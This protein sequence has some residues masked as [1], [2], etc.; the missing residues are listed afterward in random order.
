MIMIWFEV[1]R[2]IRSYKKLLRNILFNFAKV[3]TVEMYYCCKEGLAIFVTKLVFEMVI[4]VV[5]KELP[6]PFAHPGFFCVA[7]GIFSL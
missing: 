4:W 6:F 5:F 2:N 1:T 3:I 7:Q